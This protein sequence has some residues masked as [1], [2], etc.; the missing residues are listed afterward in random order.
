MTTTTS[1]KSKA[2]GAI[3]IAI[4]LVNLIV[5]CATYE[6]VG[7]YY[8]RGYREVVTFL[9]YPAI[10]LLAGVNFAACLITA[11]ANRR[12]NS[13]TLYAAAASFLISAVALLISLPIAPF[14][15][16]IL[17]HNLLLRTSIVDAARYQDAELVKILVLRGVDPNTRGALQA[18]ALHC[19]AAS[20]ETEVVELLLKHGADPNARA[21][22]MNEFPLHSAI[23]NRAPLSTI[24][25]L[26]NHGA[27]P[28][29]AD[30]EGRTALDLARGY[31]DPR[32]SLLWR[33]MIGSE[34]P[35]EAAESAIPSNP[36]SLG[37]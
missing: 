12:Q 10:L 13:G 15:G 19:M 11:A 8:I 18:T 22:L 3:V 23:F 27:D 1:P 14:V 24:E 25:A 28:R 37:K 35:R 33:A 34:P 30:R 29:L 17:N 6:S 16:Q 21:N 31:P 2:V 26:I 7:W 20:G 5:G 32:A 36:G 4:V 9:I